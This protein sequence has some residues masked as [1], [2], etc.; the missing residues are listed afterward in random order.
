MRW[1]IAAALVSACAPPPKP[2]RQPDETEYLRGYKLGKQE[3]ESEMAD[4]LR[5]AELEMARMQRVLDRQTGELDSCSASAER[6]NQEAMRLSRE[7]SKC[8]DP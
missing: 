2:C 7:L 8:Q 3:T 6:E 1:L 5:T 4:K